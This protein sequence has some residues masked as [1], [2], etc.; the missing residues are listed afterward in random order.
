MIKENMELTELVKEVCDILKTK[1]TYEDEVYYLQVKT[2]D[3]HEEEVS[4]YETID[5]YELSKIDCAVTIGPV[6]KNVD[7]L[8]TFL[9]NNFELDYGAFAI[10]HEDDID[11][12]VLVE[13]LLTDSC[14]AEELATVTAYLAEIAHETRELISKF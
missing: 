12:L 9:K 11:L 2:E 5:S 8:Y 1:Y 4:I 7:L 10:I 6:I 3:G 14:S 13:S